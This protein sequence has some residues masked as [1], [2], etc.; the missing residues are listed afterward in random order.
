[1][2]PCA[3]WRPNPTQAAIH[4]QRCEIQVDDFTEIILV[5][6]P[7]FPVI[8]PNKLTGEQVPIHQEICSMS[9]KSTQT[10]NDRQKNAFLDK[11]AEVIFKQ[12]VNKQNEK[13]QP[14]PK[15]GKPS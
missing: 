2:Y 12:G 4:K 8:Q 14:E 1:M 9:T 13:Q 15:G 11:L 10:E 3:C 5:L 6:Q 7:L